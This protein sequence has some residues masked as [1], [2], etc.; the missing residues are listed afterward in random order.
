VSHKYFGGL[1]PPPV[2]DPYAAYIAYDSVT[3]ADSTTSP[4]SATEKGGPWTVLSGTAWGVSSNQLYNPS[5]VNGALLKLGDT[6][7]GSVQGDVFS[8]NYLANPAGVFF[9]SS[10]ANNFLL[11]HL[12]NGSAILWKCIGGTFTQLTTGATSTTGGV[13]FTIRIVFSGASV[14]VL[15][16]GVA[17]I[18]SFTLTGTAASLAGTGGGFRSTIAT[19]RFDNYQMAA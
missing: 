15:V 18:T 8:V 7:N 19:N 6:L 10:D 13:A 9:R 11:V 14:T 3:R 2:T 4:G 16:G 12:S 5:G 1:L 17:V